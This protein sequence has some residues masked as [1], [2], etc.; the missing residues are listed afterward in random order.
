MGSIKF[1]TL[2]RIKGHTLS[3]ENKKV[4][5]KTITEAMYETIKGLH[6]IGLVDQATMREFDVLCLPKI[7]KLKSKKRGKK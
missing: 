6:K 5:K 1:Y 4:M 7:K 2:H 3:G